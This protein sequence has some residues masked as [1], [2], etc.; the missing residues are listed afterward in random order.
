MAASDHCFFA[1]QVHSLSIAM[2]AAKC[3]TRQI[4]SIQVIACFNEGRFRCLGSLD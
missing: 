3:E 1:E 4:G 2:P